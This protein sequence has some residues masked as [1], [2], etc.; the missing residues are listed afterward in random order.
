MKHEIKSH[1]DYEPEIGEVQEDL[2]DMTVPDLNY[3]IRQLVENFTVAPLIQRP[4]NF[5]QDDEI[6]WN[7]LIDRPKDLTDIDEYRAELET[8]NDKIKRIKDAQNKPKE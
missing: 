5:N 3:N 6:D 1:W 8:L 7:T 4:T 2:T